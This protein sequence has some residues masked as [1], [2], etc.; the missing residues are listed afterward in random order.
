MS[1]E[2]KLEVRG[3]VITILK[4]GEDNYISLTDIARYK[5][6][7]YYDLVKLFLIILD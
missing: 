2:Y 4:V 6:S 7:E 3:N 5:D 1:K